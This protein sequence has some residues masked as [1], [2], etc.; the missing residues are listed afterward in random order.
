M[1]HIFFD[2]SAFDRTVSW[3]KVPRTEVTTPTYQKV[4][5]EF[6]AGTDI[7]YNFNIYFPVGVPFKMFCWILLVQQQY[8]C[9][10]KNTTNETSN[11][12][13]SFIKFRYNWPIHSNNFS[14]GRKPTAT[15]WTG[16]G[17]AS[18]EWVV[19][20]GSPEWIGKGKL[21]IQ[22]LEKKQVMGKCCMIKHGALFLGTFFF[23]F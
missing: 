16:G 13:F 4:F 6:V 7:C 14:L 21:N 8:F 2:C 1:L 15:W 5:P 20:G 18:R 11:F 9:L 10:K 19:L 3:R 12:H 22:A 23:I 17:K